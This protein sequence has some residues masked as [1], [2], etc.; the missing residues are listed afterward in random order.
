[1]HNRVHRYAARTD[2]KR[3]HPAVKK[4]EVHEV[5]LCSSGQLAV[6]SKRSIVY[7]SIQYCLVEQRMPSNGVRHSGTRQE[8]TDRN[9]SSI[10]STIA[11]V[12][13]LPSIQCYGYTAYRQTKSFLA[14]FHLL[15]IAEPE[16]G[17][18]R[19]EVL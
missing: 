16:V 4:A 12:T 15:S 19:V 2:G 3:Y 18:E 17:H 8:R 9:T 14:V 10:T 7:E 1:M 5:A 6:K 11:Q 13:L